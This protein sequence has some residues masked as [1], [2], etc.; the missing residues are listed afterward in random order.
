MD[1]QVKFGLVENPE[2]V[3]HPSRVPGII[4]NIAFNY[5]ALG[6]NEKHLKFSRQNVKKIQIT[7][8]L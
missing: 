7:M 1:S 2:E 5:M 8:I 6:E 3:P 4:K